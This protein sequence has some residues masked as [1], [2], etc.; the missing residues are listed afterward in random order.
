MPAVALEDRLPLQ[1]VLAAHGQD[2]NAYYAALRHLGGDRGMFWDD[3]LRAWVVTSH[4]LC[5]KLFFN[6]ALSKSRLRLRQNEID[7]RFAPVLRR[8]QTILDRQMT[9]DE[10]I[11]AVRSHAHW[12]RL[13]RSRRDDAFSRLL[14]CNAEAAWADFATHAQDFYNAV[15][16]PYVSRAVAT[17]LALTDAERRAIYPLVY[18][19]AD[20]L[21]GKEA[22]GSELGAALSLSLLDDFVAARLPA[23]RGCPHESIDDERRWIADYIL[24]LVAGHESTAYAL[25]VSLVAAGPERPLPRSLPAIRSHLLEALRFD[26]PIQMV[27]RVARSS[28]VLGDVTVR[29]GERV[30]LHV[31]AANRD[32]A[33][34]AAPDEFRPERDQGR[35]LSFGLGASRCIGMKLSVLQAEIFLA[36]AARVTAERWLRLEAA[37]YAH[38]LAGRSFERLALVV[39][40]H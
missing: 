34:F 19:Y 33:Q 27:G 29:A 6:D 22:T 20:F 16:R 4:A 39:E 26:S 24:T 31:G 38:G 25:A 18:G 1:R 3:E 2:T 23:L 32:P 21:D 5:R 40:S 9:F 37:T 30:F 35:L 14:A 36:A 10:S 12:A 11:D 28:I 8:A 7:P 13:L 17:K 15:L